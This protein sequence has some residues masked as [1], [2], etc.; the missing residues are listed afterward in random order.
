LKD[1]FGEI[2][3]QTN[4][5]IKTIPLREKAKEIGFEKLILKNTKLI[6]KFTTKHTK[7]FESQ[8]FSKVLKFV[9]LNKKGVQLKEKNNQLSLILEQI[10]NIESA[11]IV[12]EKI[13]F[14]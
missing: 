10:P 14:K 12:L 6:G 13:L 8:S 11:N 3:I 4:N 2:P 9:Q 1:R 5:L 7:Y